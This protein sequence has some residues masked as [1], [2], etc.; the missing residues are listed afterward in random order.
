[1]KRPSRRTTPSYLSLG[2]SG[3]LIALALGSASARAVELSVGV[4]SGGTSTRVSNWVGDTS[5]G[6]SI[7][8]SAGTFSFGLIV[9]QRFRVPGV[10]LEIFEDVQPT[11]VMIQTGSP[12]N[13]A[14]Y[15]PVD[16]GVR[17]GLA[18][19]AVQP[20]LGAIFQG[21]FLTGHPG[22]GAPLKQAAFAVG[23]SLG[24]DLAVF[25]VRLGLEARL[26]ETVTGL[27]PSGND[28][29]PGNASVFQLL[30]SLR[31]AL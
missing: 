17:L 19:S 10:L 1:M 4:L 18:T 3:L 6:E 28:P 30:L 13:T 21:L 23:G 12:T 15:L 27:S 26:T 16:L 9:E 14:G 5:G 20:Y 25:F 2:A 11:P 31:S 24:V 7:S 29:N 8:R 22:A